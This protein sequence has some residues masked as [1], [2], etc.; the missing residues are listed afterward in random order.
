MDTGIKISVFRSD[1][2]FLTVIATPSIL[3]FSCDSAPSS[4]C[5]R[6]MCTGSGDTCLKVGCLTV[7]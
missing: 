4:H 5:L 6:V 2:E 1:E 7:E 3:A